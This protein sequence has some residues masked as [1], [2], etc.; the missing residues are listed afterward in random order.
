MKERGINDRSLK[1]WKQSDLKDYG[2]E[3]SGK[4]G[5]KLKTVSFYPVKLISQYNL[6]EQVIGRWEAEQSKISPTV[7]Y[8]SHFLK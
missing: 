3:Q 8:Y 5:E 7:T 2:T 1:G 6:K 4:S